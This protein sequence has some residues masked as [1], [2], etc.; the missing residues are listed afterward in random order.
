[1]NNSDK[2]LRAYSSIENYL[3]KQTGNDKVIPFPE[4]VDR[5][6]MSNSVVK[7]F[8]KDLKKYNRL[9]NVIIHEQG[10]IAEVTEKAVNQLNKIESLL[11]KPPTIFPLFKNVVITIESS[12]SVA[13]AA[14]LMY[15][16]T[17]SQLP[18]KNGDKSSNLLTTNTI[19]RWLGAC[20]KDD[21]FSLEETTVL[22]VLQYTED[23]DNHYFMGKNTNIFE[24]LDKFQDYERRGKRLE[25]ILI[26]ENGKANEE[27][28]GIMTIA[29]LPKA[30]EKIE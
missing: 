21:I 6:S 30:L 14:E 20:S 15:T 23:K 12:D 18:V 7:R 13:R 22:M 4:L 27:V 29:D 1:M 3:R 10:L 2:F 19:T 28:I 24:A 17:I 16:N 25:A 26:T 8:D 11:L 5:I 9:R